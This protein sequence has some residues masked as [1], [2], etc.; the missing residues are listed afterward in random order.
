[1]LKVL[2]PNYVTKIDYEQRKMIED[3]NCQRMRENAAAAAGVTTSKE[4]PKG[5][6][7]KGHFEHV[8]KGSPGDFVWPKPPG[9]PQQLWEGHQHL[10]PR[11]GW[12][13]GVELWRSGRL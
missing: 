11:P 2:F 4:A 3:A 13:H 12:E 10:P 6:V 1:M 5:D 7:G 9:W 8:G